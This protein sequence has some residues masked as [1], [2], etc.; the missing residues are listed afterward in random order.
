MADTSITKQAA[1]Q[2]QIDAAIRMLFLHNEDLVAIHT[3]AAAA[4]TITQDLAEARGVGHTYGTRR[5]LEELYRKDYGVDPLQ[6]AVKAEIAYR[7]D[8]IEKDGRTKFLRNKTAN[9]LKH[10][11]R[12]SEKGLDIGDLD[13]CWIIAD[14]IDLWIN[15]K[16]SLSD[17]MWIYGQ[18]F[19]AVT[20]NTAENSI[21]TKSGPV[22]GFSFKQ[23]IEFGRYMLKGI[24]ML[25]RRSA[26]SFRDNSAH[27]LG[28][29]RMYCV[30]D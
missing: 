12:D 1:A 8:E 2:R 24:Y 7:A 22:S 29:L 25:K 20:A 10:A 30:L 14:T 23:Q 27:Q 15:L 16:L 11:D 4:R 9:Y 3:V 21:N 18:W 5:A 28:S 19:Y 6:P 26:K 13:T 17:E